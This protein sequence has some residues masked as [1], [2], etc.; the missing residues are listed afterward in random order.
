MTGHV[1]HLAQALLLEGHVAYRQYFI[2]DQDFRLQVSGNGECQADI[3]PAG[4]SLDR[5]IQEFLDLGEATIWSNFLSISTFLM[6]RMV[7]LR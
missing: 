6:P 5:R 1:L 4:V 2:D 3:H 7:P